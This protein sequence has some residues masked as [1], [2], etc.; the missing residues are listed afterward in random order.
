MPAQNK[1]H[2]ALRQCFNFHRPQQRNVFEYVFSSNVS[3]GPIVEMFAKALKTLD[4]IKE[5]AVSMDIGAESPQFEET[6]GLTLFRA[7]LCLRCNVMDGAT[8]IPFPP[9]PTDIS[10]QSASAQVLTPLFNFLAW[11]LLGDNASQGLA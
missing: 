8:R 4:N 3:L 1:A 7:A 2:P 11:L 6:P 10:D 9:K 5:T